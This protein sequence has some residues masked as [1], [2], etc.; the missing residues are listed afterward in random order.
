MRTLKLYGIPSGAEAE[1]PSVIQFVEKL[2]RENL[3]IPSSTALQI[4]TAYQALFSPPPNGSLPRS[5]VAK[6]LCFTVK[7]EV[8]RLACQKKSFFLWNNNKL[9][10]DHEYP[11][12]IIAMQKEYTEVRRILKEKNLQFWTTYPARCLFYEGWTKIYNTVEDV[13]ADMATWA[14]P[15]KTIEPPA[16]LREKL[17]RWSLWQSAGGQCVR[18]SGGAAGYK[19]RLQVFRRD[20]S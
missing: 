6:F 15:V 4:Q 20:E 9:N 8:L 18:E 7:E 2:L 5:I 3:N 17:K 1:A 12:E 19:E 11:P 10:L 14:Q 13:M 16:N